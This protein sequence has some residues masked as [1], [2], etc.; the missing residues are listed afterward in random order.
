MEGLLPANHPIH[1]NVVRFVQP[2][3]D[4]RPLP[5]SK[6]S[7][8]LD[9]GPSERL[10]EGEVTLQVQAQNH[11]HMMSDIKSHTVVVTH[12]KPTLTGE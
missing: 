8:V 7:A 2:L 1:L 12:S 10:P 11:R 5:V 3:A 9:K 4:W 6:T